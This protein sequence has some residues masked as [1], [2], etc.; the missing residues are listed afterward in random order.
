MTRLPEAFTDRMKKLL[1]EEYPD[2]LASYD[3]PRHHGLRLNT[4][5]ISP[6]E[7]MEKSDFHLSPISWIPAAWYYLKEDEAARHPFYYGGLYYLQEPSAMTPASL[8]EI[9]PGDR[10][11]DLCAAPGG[12]STALGARLKGKGV[13]VANDISASRCKALL[14]NLEVFGVPN[15]VVTNAA[16]EKLSEHFPE[17]FDAVLV[18]AP[19]SG[20][21]MFRKDEATIAA[22]YPEK[23]AD[24]AKMQ[25]QIVSQAVKMLRPGGKLLY[26]TCTFAVE[27]DEETVQFI[28]E[29]FPEMSLCPAA[30]REGFAGGIGGG[31]MDKCVRLWPHKT[32]GEGH[33]LALFKKEGGSDKA[34]AG[35]GSEET[36]Q[37][38]T[39]AGKQ[40]LMAAFPGKLQERGTIRA[41]AAKKDKK[42][43]RL[44]G[45]TRTSYVREDGREMGSRRKKERYGGGAVQA[46]AT[47]A[48]KLSIVGEFLEKTS[49]K[50]PKGRVV[51][52]GDSVYLWPED[53]TTQMLT[54]I[55]YLRCGLL[56]GQFVSGR[57]EPSQAMAMAA[58]TGSAENIIRLQPDDE[59][60]I[61]Y[62]RGET[63][64]IR[65]DELPHA[66]G[67]VLIAADNYALGWGKLSGNVVKNKYL[68][69]WRARY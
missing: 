57:F 43:M 7:F 35:S 28:L 63:I 37:V 52:Q 55:T 62:L 5:K 40:D 36:A 27:E 48:E 56:V 1:G 19:C 58:D 47:A 51:L 23:P 21:G 50:L 42:A 38:Y 25:R 30:Q 18:D 15:A 34:V 16:P 17:Y 22:W 14:K 54:G 8:L 31:Q 3:Q 26:S 20:E 29:N 60:L 53:I 9:T 24:C 69:G 59:R 2:F 46:E 4:L 64:Q 33:F 68:P 11:L 41:A 6:E 66:G 12:K 39:I 10:V 49:L 45:D 32:G 67:W 13:L 61:H 44:K 65:D